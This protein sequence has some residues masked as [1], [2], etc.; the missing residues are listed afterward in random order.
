M[1][2]LNLGGM[3]NFLEDYMQAF[4]TQV[5]QTAALRHQEENK[6][7]CFESRY[8]TEAPELFSG[9]FVEAVARARA[10]QRLMHV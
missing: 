3:R 1:S 9:T 7:E 8:G 2:V 4:T 5:D 6:R 10:K